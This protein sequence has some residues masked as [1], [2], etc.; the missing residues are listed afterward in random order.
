MKKL[1]IAADF[2]VQ[3]WIQSKPL[4]KKSLFNRGKM[5]E[6]VKKNKFQVENSKDKKDEDSDS[7][8]EFMV[9]PDL[10]TNSALFLWH[11]Q[12]KPPKAINMKK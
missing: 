4:G 7:D 11:D 6:W 5:R 2:I 3:D 10:I 12:R 9:M 8:Q 1:P